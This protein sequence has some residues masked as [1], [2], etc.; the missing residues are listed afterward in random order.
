MANRTING[1]AVI[2]LG[3]MG[4]SLA[5]S[6]VRRGIHV[7][8]VDR[9]AAVVQSLAGDLPHVV[10][11]DATDVEVLRD[12]KLHLYSRV[13]VTI[14]ENLEASVLATSLLAQMGI[15]EIWAKA[16][17]GQHG[18][19]LTRMGAHHLVHPD[20]EAGERLSHLLADNI[21][22]YIELDRDY[23]F[24]KTTVPGRLVGKTL[25]EA[26]LRSRYGVTVVAIKKVGAEFSYATADTRAEATDTLIIAGPTNA[27]EQFAADR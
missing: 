21:Q 25:A 5:R 13:V 19:V 16:S 18:R 26:G 9:D 3:R 20:Q 10:T 17:T 23:A 8:A 12:L 4:G 6:L 15:P 22:D 24:I 14:G 27:V 7:L 1:I 2:G 11:A